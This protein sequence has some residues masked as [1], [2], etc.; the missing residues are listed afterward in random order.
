[1]LLLQCVYYRTERSQNEQENSAYENIDGVKLADPNGYISK[2]KFIL[3]RVLT[4]K[5]SHIIL[6]YR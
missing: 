4:A 2:L 1:M 3:L 5:C 6:H